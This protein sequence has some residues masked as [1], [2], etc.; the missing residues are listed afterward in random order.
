MDL[1]FPGATAAATAMGFI[2]NALPVIRMVNVFLIFYTLANLCSPVRAAALR[3]APVMKIRD[4]EDWARRST[5]PLAPGTVLVAAPGSF[6]HY[7]QEAM[8][9]VLEHGDDGTRG[10]LVNHQMPWEVQD[11]NEALTAFEGQAVYLGGDRG[12]DTMLMLHRLPLVKG[13]KPVGDG[14]VCLGGL[15]DAVGFVERGELRASQFKFVYKTSEWLPGALEREL[16][17]DLWTPIE[18]SPAIVLDDGQRTPM[19]NHVR[20]LLRQESEEEARKAADDEFMPESPKADAARAA[21]PKADAPPAP[22]A[23]AE[24]GEVTEVVGFRVFKGREQWQCRWRGCDPDET[25]WEAWGV[26]DSAAARARAEELRS[27]A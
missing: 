2:A 12:A 19:W 16:A 7:F 14:G 24:E 23:A 1:R 4:S 9:L 3:A 25:S 13:A 27:S 15:R 8:V 21:P 11:M 20:A 5:S 10:V 18:T 6:D 26:L 22:P 17:D